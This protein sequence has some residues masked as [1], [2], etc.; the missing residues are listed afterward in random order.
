M[1]HWLA[2]HAPSPMDTSPDR[3]I[4]SRHTG[5][6]REIFELSRWDRLTDQEKLVRS[7]EVSPDPFRRRPDLLFSR[8]RT[9]TSIPTTSSTSPGRRNTTSGAFR[10]FS[11]GA[12][13]S[14]GGPLAADTGGVPMHAVDDGRGGYTASGSNAPL[15][16]ANFFA[17]S[18][19][20]SD[21]DMYE[22]RLALALDVDASKRMVISP[23]SSPARSFSRGVVWKDNEWMKEGVVTRKVQEFQSLRLSDIS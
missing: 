5:S 12:V 23:G 4:P 6:P 10:S 11:G 8:L 16:T 2:S 15:Y 7:Y 17:A 20:V 9:S 1:L 22:R 14:V 13:W 21:G 3:F 18:D 19:P